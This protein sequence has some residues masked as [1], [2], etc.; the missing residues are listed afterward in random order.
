MYIS[1][2]DAGTF[3]LREVL[4]AG[5]SGWEAFVDYGQPLE[6]YEPVSI[7]TV[8]TRPNSNGVIVL[9]PIVHCL[10]DFNDDD[11]V[12]AAD[13]TPFIQ[14]FLHGEP[15]ADLTG[16]GILDVQD[17]FLFLEL[18]SMGCVTG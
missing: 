5:T 2:P 7:F 14:A 1:I 13:I 8:Q 10:G 17:Q 6:A 16:D 18:A 12:N 4:Q 3:P 9:M 15:E 11:V